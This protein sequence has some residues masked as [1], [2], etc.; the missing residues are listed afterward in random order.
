LHRIT[1]DQLEEMMIAF[2]EMEF[3]LQMDR[4]AKLEGD[5]Q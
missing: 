4:Y 5:N 2:E 3:E 1:P